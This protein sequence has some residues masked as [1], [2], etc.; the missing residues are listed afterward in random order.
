MKITR[1]LCIICAVFAALTFLLTNAGPPEVSKKALSYSGKTIVISGIVDDRILKNNVLQVYLSADADNEYDIEGIILY[2]DNYEQIEEYLCLGRRITV[3][4]VFY[5]FSKPY[6]EGNFDQMSYYKIRGYDGQL[7]RFRIEGATQSY[8]RLKE[9]LRHI[10]DKVEIIISKNLSSEDAGV[11]N[12]ML[13]GDKSGLDSQI[14]EQY[15]NAGIS[16]LLALSG[17]H[18]ASIGLCLLKLLNKIGLK[19]IPSSVISGTILV[20]YAIMTGAST[21]TVRALIMFILAVAAKCIGRSY[22]LITAA[23]L[24]MIGILLENPHY[25]YDSGFLLSFGAIMGIAIVYP[26]LEEMTRIR[27]VSIDEKREEHNSSELIRNLN[28]GKFLDK[29]RQALCISLSITVVTL[30][31]TAYSFMQISLYA[32]ILNLL[33]IPLMS[34]VLFAGIVGVIVGFSRVSAAT[35]IFKITHA[36]LLFYNISSGVTTRFKGNL[37][38]TGR[39]SAVRI[40]IYVVLLALA[41]VIYYGLTILSKGDT[42]FSEGDTDSPIKKSSLCLKPWVIKAAFVLLIMIA[43]FELLGRRHEEL[44][45]R[46]LYVGQGDCAVICGEN[47]P[48]I[49]IDAGSTDVKQVGKYKILP[50]LKANKLATIDY[51]FL[52]HMDADHVNGIFEILE[53]ETCGINIE[54]VIIS[55]SYANSAKR[56]C[57]LETKEHITDDYYTRLNQLAGNGRCRVLLM[58]SG[59]EIIAG[60]LR[61]KCLSPNGNEEYV[62]NDSSIVL[63]IKYSDT[64]SDIGMDMF[65]TGDISSE[66]ERVIDFSKLINDNNLITYL[67]VAHHGSRYSTSEDFLNKVKPHLAVIS[68]GIDNSYGHPHEEAL[69]RI[70]ESESGPMILRTDESG[71]ITVMV[72]KGHVVVKRFNLR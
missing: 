8:N 57:E 64:N 21:S 17:L 31:I 62:G 60:G 6:N 46:N 2:A 65:F 18:I 45:I 52:T 36:I 71:Q 34:G 32:V 68:A 30:P 10:R 54:N 9:K 11:L 37:Y 41:I 42:K 3:K 20:L 59:D 5:P 23:S 70:K 43:I 22:D 69:L 44:E 48:T 7:K 39:P 25:L 33:V 14:K 53:D 58:E 55:K 51:C 50:A 47:I 56:E 72:E 63:A 40:V 1:P 66:R 61:I 12:A 28:I 19:T 49:M 4:G 27:V 67:K 38:I 16:H 15:Q 24:S 26:I 29:I 13:L 35:I